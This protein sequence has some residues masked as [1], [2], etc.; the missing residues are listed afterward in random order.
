MLAVRSKAVLAGD[1]RTFMSTVSH[2]SAD[3]VRDQARLFAAI[4]RVPL[5]SYRL[6]AVWAR[7]GDLA[8]ATDRARYSGAQRVAI[9]VTE[10]RYRIQGFDGPA[11]EED[12]FYTFVEQGGRWQ[13]ASDSDLNDLGFESARELWDFGPV[14]VRRSRHFMLL[15]HPCS[16]P[17]GCARLPSDVLGLAETALR[18]VD[19]YWQRPWRHRIVISAPTTDAELTRILQATFDVNKFVAFAYSSEDIE[20]G[21]RFIGRRIILNWH[22]LA[23]RSSGSV[24]TILAHELTHVATRSSSGPQIPTFVEEGIAEYVGYNA[25]PS[26]LSYLDSVVS[27]GGFDGKLPRDYQFTTG[28]ATEIFLSY[29]KAESAVGY[30][31]QRW[32]LDR[33]VRFYRG[34][35]RQRVVTGTARWH[36]GHALQQTIGIGFARFQK[37]WAS[38][39]RQ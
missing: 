25:Q 16:A 26:S 31:I 14:S 39:L 13:V 4:T 18:R 2:G 23:N 35:G 15:S 10:E 19:R 3:F 37:E 36:L 29:Q 27:T 38:S 28:S 9:P 21:L 33:F 34:L 30:F 5:R 1:K 8:R 6:R 7:Y 24:L 17:I 12:L 22:A 20:H 32:G 11:V